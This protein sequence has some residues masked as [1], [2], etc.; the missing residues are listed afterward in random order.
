MVKRRV[1]RGPTTMIR[2]MKHDKYLRCSTLLPVKS[3]RRAL[4]VETTRITHQPN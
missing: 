1:W 2:T 3:K 4:R